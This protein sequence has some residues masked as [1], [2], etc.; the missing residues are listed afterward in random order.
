MYA[1]RWRLRGVIVTH[2]SFFKRALA[3][4]FDLA[5][6]N[7]AVMLFTDVAMGVAG[8]DMSPEKLEQTMQAMSAGESVDGVFLKDVI[9]YGMLLSFIS[10][11]AVVMV[12]A[13]MPATKMMASPGKAILGMVVVDGQGKRL[14]YSK[15]FGRHAAKFISLVSVFGFFMP[16]WHPKRQALHDTICATFVVKKRTLEVT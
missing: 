1:I 15:A 4:V 12:D 13:I 9:F 11:I 16:L 8:V 7:I 3:M 5:V 10:V 2:S 14:S 6:I